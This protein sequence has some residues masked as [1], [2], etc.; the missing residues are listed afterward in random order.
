MLE[1]TGIHEE[2]S[3]VKFCFSSMKGFDPGDEE[4]RNNRIVILPDG[5]KIIRPYYFLISTPRKDVALRIVI[6]MK[7]YL[8]GERLVLSEDMNLKVAQFKVVNVKTFP[9]KIRPD[10]ELITDTPVI[11]RDHSIIDKKQGKYIHPEDPNYI[12]A[13]KKNI[14]TKWKKLFNE[15]IDENFFKGI[16]I[17]LG[18][19]NKTISLFKLKEKDGSK[20]NKYLFVTGRRVTLKLDLNDENFNFINKFSQLIDAGLGVHSTFGCGFVSVMKNVQRDR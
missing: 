3:P 9:T 13:L 12:P 7:K 17:I 4:L 18:D 10:D 16:K 20:S 19:K 2:H 1:G 6:G 5:R 8:R 14:K 15:N 11:L